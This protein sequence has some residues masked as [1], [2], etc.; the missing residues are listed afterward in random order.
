M[1]NEFRIIRDY[2]Q[3]NTP[4]PGLLAGVGDDG[5]VLRPPADRD[6]LVV[7]DTLVEGRH[8]PAGFAAMDIG[9]RALAVNLSDIAA[10]G[11]IPRFAFLNL[12]LPA[13]DDDWLRSF[14]RGFFELADRHAVVL[15]GGDTTSGSL[16]IT[17]TVI[18]DVKPGKALLRNGARP[19]DLV[20]VSGSPGDAAAGLEQLQHDNACAT[21][22]ALRFRRPEPRL[23]LGAA[24]AG[25]A[26]A[27]I[28]ISDGLLA[29]LGHILESSNVGARIEVAR[30]PLSQSLQE[31]ATRPADY[32]LAG[33]DDYE[34]CFTLPASA[35]G[36]L[37]AARP[38]C[39]ISVIGEIVAGDGVD[40]VDANGEPYRVNRR[41]WQHFATGTIE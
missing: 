34:L 18:G 3:R 40:V 30:L 6:Q 9:W 31:F 11:G 26:T 5:A 29:D 16:S 7:T 28:D 20:C 2:F 8:F 22:L 19:G 14:A 39:D 17:V 33:G 27:A 21:P 32:A 1:N 25:T 23:A 24:L 15:A 36:A 13:V 4:A 35:L 10:M 41:G 37:Q 38:G 12:T